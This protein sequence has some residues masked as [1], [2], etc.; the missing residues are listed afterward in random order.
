[1]LRRMAAILAAL[2]L[3]LYWGESA[4]ADVHDGDAEAPSSV[5]QTTAVEKAPQPSDTPS[6]PAPSHSSDSPHTCHCTHV[7]GTALPM[8]VRLQPRPLVV[9]HVHWLSD[10]APVSISPEPHFRPPVA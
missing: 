1:M 6:D 3:V 7:H 4:V 10:T 8:A 9:P 2:G 5:A